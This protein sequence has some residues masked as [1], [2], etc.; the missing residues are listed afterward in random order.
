MTEFGV[1]CV[2]PKWLPFPLVGRF[3]TDK[4]NTTRH[5]PIVKKMFLFRTRIQPLS[6]W[7]KMFKRNL[8]PFGGNI[9]FEVGQDWRDGPKITG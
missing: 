9:A 7:M 8:A 2:V 6:Y 3:L 1:T 4:R 5:C